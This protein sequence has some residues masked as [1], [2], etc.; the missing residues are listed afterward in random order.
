MRRA[1]TFAHNVCLASR[2]APGQ[3]YAYR[4]H[5]ELGAPARSID[6]FP[7]ASASAAT[8]LST[9]NIE[10]HPHTNESKHP[11]AHVHPS[12]KKMTTAPI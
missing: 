11:P 8:S 4:D 2:G 1:A 3:M 7:A 12:S 9:L 10:Q 6:G 5:P